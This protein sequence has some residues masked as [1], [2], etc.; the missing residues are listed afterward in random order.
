MR[1]VLVAPEVA[2]LQEI[3]RRGVE[4]GEVRADNPAP[5]YVLAMMFGVL[6]IRPVLTGR[7]ADSDY[8][9]SFMEA[10]VLPALR[11]T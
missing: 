9:V 11:L 7:F 1:E 5:A 3:L 2:A 6:R 8:L 4:R 10:A